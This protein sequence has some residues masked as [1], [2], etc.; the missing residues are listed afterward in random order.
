M[1]RRIL[2]V[3]VVFSA[4]LL[5]SDL[6]AQVGI[7]TELPTNTLH[8]KPLDPN[9]DPLRVE[10]LNNFM[11]GDSALLVVDPATGVVRY[12]HIDSLLAL[13]QQYDDPDNDPTNELQNALEVPIEPA[14]D[15]DNNGISEQNMHH[16]IWVLGSKL[17][18]GTFKSI[19]E[20]RDAG[21][22]DGDSFL[23][24]PKGVFGCS[25]CTITLHPGMD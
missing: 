13:I 7:G 2:I 14:I 3:L 15:L 23:A 5:L 24:D 6:K 17:P 20:A 1:K 11:Q 9:E 22:V 10:N 12:L 21:L 4:S 18:K 8:V 19:G 25:G 16:A